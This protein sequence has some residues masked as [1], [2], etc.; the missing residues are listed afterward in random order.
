MIRFSTELEI[1]RS[2]YDRRTR[3]GR[4]LVGRR[5][6]VTFVCEESTAA[7]CMMECKKQMWCS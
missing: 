3:S 1:Y 7:R 2:T 6:V 5:L 4:R